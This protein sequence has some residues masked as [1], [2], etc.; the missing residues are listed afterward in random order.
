M[1][2]STNQGLHDGWWHYY[3]HSNDRADQYWP[4]HQGI[5]LPTKKG[6]KEQAEPITVY[7]AIPNMA[8]SL[9]SNMH[10]RRKIGMSD[11]STTH[12]LQQLATKA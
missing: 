2:T 1:A 6:N 7:R 10:H 3:E 8:Q 9:K 5:L 4:H 12:I 11:S